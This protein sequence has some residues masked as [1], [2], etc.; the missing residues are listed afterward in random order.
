MGRKNTKK[1]EMSIRTKIY[2]KKKMLLENA[3]INSWT[4]L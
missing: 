1:I 3:N 4:I 2:L